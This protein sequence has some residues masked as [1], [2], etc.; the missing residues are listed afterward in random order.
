MEM[1]CSENEDKNIQE[2]KKDQNREK[3]R[4]ILMKNELKKEES[5]IESNNNSI[6]ILC[7]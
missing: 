2:K 5:I 3:I 1:G 6:N 7:K 4:K